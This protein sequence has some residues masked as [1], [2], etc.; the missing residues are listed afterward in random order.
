M[1][2]FSVL[3]LV[4][5]LALPARADTVVD[6]NVDPGGAKVLEIEA[7]GAAIVFTP[8][9]NASSIHVVV[10][11]DR[12]TP[13]PMMESSRAG[14]RLTLTLK[15]P[16]GAPLI[17]FVPSGG[18]TYTVTYPAALRLD[19]RVSSGDVRIAQPS[20][21][22]E[23]FDEDGNI[24]VDSPRAAITAENARGDITVSGALAP[25]DLAADDGNV[26]ASVA[27]GWAGNEIR[28]Q[29]GTGTIHL[30]VPR[31]FRGKVDASSNGGTVHDTA[32]VI[33]ARTPFVWLYAIK[34]DVWLAPLNP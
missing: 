8:S 19:L 14:N 3:V 34:G 25:I 20:S 33:A 27:A 17:P 26:T 12:S 23:I 5:A 21:S 28:I 30:S 18:A 2:P 22:V 32:H 10:D 7:G 29:S 13:V 4:L 1:R 6:R 16:S 24:V 31:A 11:Q 9:A 15:P